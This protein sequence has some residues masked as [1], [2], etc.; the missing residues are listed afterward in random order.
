MK[1]PGDRW[2]TYINNRSIQ[3][4]HERPNSY[5]G[6]RDPWIVWLLPRPRLDYYSRIVPHS[7]LK[8]DQAF[9]GFSPVIDG[10]DLV[11]LFM[12]P[13]GFCGNWD[14]LSSQ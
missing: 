11:V 10:L 3:H 1:C 14:K 6:K 8:C 4:D 2:E 7:F 12:S 9:Y 5:Q 13:S